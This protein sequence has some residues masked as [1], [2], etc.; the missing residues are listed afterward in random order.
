M[1]KIGKLAKMRIIAVCLVLAFINIGGYTSSMGNPNYVTAS[2][3]VSSPTIAVVKRTATTA[4][5]SISK[6]ENASGY[7]IYRSTSQYGTYQYVGSTQSNTFNDSAL[8]ADSQYVY[9]AKAYTNTGTSTVYSSYSNVASVLATLAR[10]QN[11]TATGSSTTITVEWNTVTNASKYYV[12]RSNTSSGNYAYIGNTTYLSYSDKTAAAGQKYYY[13]V[14]GYRSLS[15]VSYYGIYSTIM[16]TPVS[17][18][19]GTTAINTG[20]TGNTGYTIP[21][22]GTTTNTTAGTSAGTTTSST[23]ATATSSNAQ[24]TS[25]V[26]RLVNIERSKAGL[27]ALT[28]YATIEKAA[29][30]RAKEIKQSFSH[31]RPNGSS[32]FTALAEVGITYRA[33]GENIAYGQRTPSEVVNAWMN[34]PGHRA[35]IMSANFSKIG[36]GCYIVNNT[37]YWTQLFTN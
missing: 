14:R 34:S 2:T 29:F 25:E 33:A 27:S 1:K 7:R 18:S 30:T 24:Y 21:T 12:Y 13:K 6:V 5:L 36:V 35:N 23:G 15:G 11:V 8:R 32:P 26:L 16:S 28:T 17:I 9:K 31:T 37:V 10:P 3:T 4:Q 22:T 19:T 20:S